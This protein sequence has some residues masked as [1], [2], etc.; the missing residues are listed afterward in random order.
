MKTALLFS[1]VLLAA[2]PLIGQQPNYPYST[3]QV[4]GA[5]GGPPS[6]G[7]VNATQY[8]IN[9]V[10]ISVSGGPFLPLEGGVPMTGNL[11]IIPPAQLLANENNTLRV[12][13]YPSGGCT[14]NS[15]TSTTQLGCAFNSAVAK[16][17]TT[18]NSVTLLIGTGYYFTDVELIEPTAGFYSVNL[19]GSGMNTTFILPSVSFASPL[20]VKKGGYA[21]LFLSDLTFQPNYNATA[22]YELAYLSNFVIRNVNCIAQITGTAHAIQIGASGAFASGGVIDNVWASPDYVIGQTYASLTAVSGSGG[23]SSVTVNSGGTY[24]TS[25]YGVVYFNDPHHYCTVLPTA[26]ATFTSTAV[27]SI[28]MVTNGTCSGGLPDVVVQQQQN[29]AIGADLWVSDTSVLNMQPNVGIIGAEIHGGN[30]SVI[31]AHPTSVQ[32]G[33][34]INNSG[35]TLLAGTECDAIGSVCLEQA[36]T[37]GISVVGTNP[38]TY[39]N[40]NGSAVMKFDS[41]S[42]AGSFS[43]PGDL[44]PSVTPTDYQEFITGTGVVLPGGIGWPSAFS[45]VSND[46]SCASSTKTDYA[47]ATGHFTSLNAN[48]SITTPLVNTTTNCSSSASPAVCAA[49]PAGSAAMPTNAVSS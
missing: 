8:E 20:M 14:A 16:A 41:T 18:G 1:L 2:S 29:I 36:T 12:D 28:T 4:P 22:C 6:A 11:P 48:T 3:V 21:N 46:Q 15:V 49:A 42:D 26:T 7:G 13:A 23:V 25:A 47:A 43:S 35:N 19:I 32:T 9:G 37:Q 45:V 34:V 38:Y 27:T 24:P 5:T 10:P 40:L 30:N 33:I 31:H 17:V 39:A 44:C